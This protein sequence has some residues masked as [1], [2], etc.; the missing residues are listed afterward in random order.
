MNHSALRICAVSLN[1]IFIVFFF[2]LSPVHAV[3]AK[4]WDGKKYPFT[5]LDPSKTNSESNPFII[6]TPGKLAY[7]SWL[8]KSDMDMEKYGRENGLNGLKYAFQDNFVKLAADLDMNGSQFEFI[9]IPDTAATFDGNGHVI[10]NL[11]ISDTTTKPFID[12]DQGDAEIRLA[13]FQSGGRI[14]N[15]GIG[16]G[17]SITYNNVLKK[18]LLKVYAAAIAAEAW[19]IDNC[20]SD[21][22]VTV[23]GNGE[24]TV[25]GIAAKAGKVTNSYN[26]GAIVF[27]GNVV[28]SKI[29]NRTGKDIPATLR[30]AG[31]CAEPGEKISG[32]YNTGSIIVRASGDNVS[33]GG[34]AASLRN[35]ECVDLYNTGN[36]TLFATGNIRY[37]Y[38]GGVLGDGFTS[39]RL[40][41]RP[42]KYLESAPIYNK[43]AIDVTLKTGE[44]IS[45]GGISG[46]MNEKR[47]EFNSSTVAFGGVYGFINTYNTGSVLVSSSGKVDTLSVGGIAG[48]GSM[49]F[50]SYNTGRVSGDSG[51]GTFL[52]VGGIGG[53]KVYI[54]NSYSTGAVS[55]NGAGTNR[56]GGLLGHANVR[57]GET[58][59]TLF[60][61]LNGFWLRQPQA[62]GINNDIQYAKGSYYYDANNMK[63]DSFYGTVY[64]FDS[65]DASVLARTDDGPG[66]RSGLNSTLLDTLNQTAEDNSDRLYRKWQ[67]DGTN[68]KYPVLSVT[69]STSKLTAKTADPVTANLIAG[70]Y[71]GVHRHWTD[72][73]ILDANGTFRRATGGD[74]GTWSYD[75][76]RLV[77]KWKKWA[78]E[79]LMQKAPGV[80]ASTKY[81]FTLT[82]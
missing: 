74:S 9:P 21:A 77:L 62:G 14:K 27:E 60:A 69:A 76:T 30:V 82:R 75:G 71:Q 73:V 6:D 43:G 70:E 2:C 44:L 18:P 11:R 58:D 17:S 23:K 81:K 24:S 66:K 80:F 41:G 10:F 57:W 61:V 40:T 68:G 59:N 64:S 12:R 36:V 1:F 39:P 37:A 29:K 35:I 49:V 50:N 79:T 19:E 22:T 52:A 38:I 25:G 32:S 28:D 55:G 63:E 15:L 67:I 13:L 72:K 16:K 54:Q 3:D 5:L 8:A 78:A 20:F 42:I 45:V 4:K 56:A 53:S 7:F 26:R 46:G 31:V 33:V 34:V 47:Y 48:Y 65:A 51:A